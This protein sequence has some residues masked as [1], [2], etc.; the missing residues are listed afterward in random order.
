MKKGSRQ[1]AMNRS[2]QAGMYI[3]S[4]VAL[5]VGLALASIQSAEAQQPKKAPR[6]GVLA[7]GSPSSAAHQHDAFRQGLRDLGYIEEQNIIVE[8]RFAEGKIDRFPDLAAEMVH[9]KVNI[10]V[11]GGTRLTS[12]AKQA[13]NTIPIVVGSAGDLIGEGVVDSLARPGGNVTGSTNI[14]PDVSGKRLELLKEVLP[15][16]SRVAVLWEHSPGSLNELRETETAARALGVK[17]QSQQIRSAN[18]FDSA[19]SAMTGERADALIIIQGSLTLFHRT[20]LLELAVKNRMA[21]I[22]EGLA[23]AND[24][25]LMSYGPD[26]SYQWRRAAIFVDKILKGTK[27]ADLPVEQ[28]M[29]FELI[30]NLKTAKQIGLTIPQS[31]LY[32][33]DRVIK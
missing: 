15:R 29:K 20:Q 32:R 5:L 30:I 17:L 9:L 19:Y 8:Y 11:V 31:V 13:T 27:P 16:A 7:A 22:C 6:I 14:S 28:P 23:W 25:C 18:D 2:K 21:S 33:A 26:L 10:I 12:A 3:K 24:G 4:V 1:P